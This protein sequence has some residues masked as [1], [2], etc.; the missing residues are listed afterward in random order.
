M[1]PVIYLLALHL[2]PSEFRLE[3]VR[4]DEHGVPAKIHGTPMKAKSNDTLILIAIIVIR[5]IGVYVCRSIAL[6]TY[7]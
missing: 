5:M 6:Y 4:L 3:G 1:L 2:L 7:K